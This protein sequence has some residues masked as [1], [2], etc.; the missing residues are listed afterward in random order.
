MITKYIKIVSQNVW[1]NNLIV[2]TILKTQFSFN[3]IFIQES[4]W[5]TIHL[6]L[7]SRS[8]EGKE[9]VRVLNYSNWL[10]FARN[11]SSDNSSPRVITYINIRLLSFQFSLYRDLFNHRDISLISF[12]N[13]SIILFLMNVYSDSSQSTLKYLKNTEANFHNFLVITGNFNI[14][15]SLWNPLY[16]HYS[17]CSNFFLNS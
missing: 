17:S 4:S 9:L 16:P 15:D 6:I 10:I 12:F 2:N 14:R 8:I 3:V 1:K 7:S 11:L 13:N 5:T